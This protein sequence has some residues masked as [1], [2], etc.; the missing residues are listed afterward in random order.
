MT[1][2]GALTVL[3]A[4]DD[5]DGL[6]PNG[7]LVHGSD[8]NFY[9]TTLYGGSHNLG[10]V[11]KITPAG[12]LTTLH[13]FQGSP[14]DGADPYRGLVQGTDGNFYGT[15]MNGGASG[16]CSTG[17]GTVFRIT[18]R[19]GLTTLHSFSVSDGSSPQAGLLQGTDGNFYG[20][21]S[22]GGLYSYGTVFKLSVG[23]KPFVASQTYSG[24]VG[25]NVIILGNNLTGS[26]A[27]S[28]NG[29]ASSFNV[30]SAS[31]IT[32]TVPADATTGKIDVTTPSGTLTSNTPFYVTP[33]VLSFTPPSGAVGTQVQI[34]G[35]SLTQ[36]AGVTFGGVKA[37][38]FTVDSDT[39][40]TAT[41]PT[42]A[43]TGVVGISTPGGTAWSA[44]NFTVQ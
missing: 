27:V 6:N 20:T 15:T 17:C 34:T 4:F 42:S 41:V 24:I 5:T 28:F 10:T 22:G 7:E 9:G 11:F 2:A 23:L 21:T 18:P 43:V 31:E 29:T 8:G 33:Q 30:V 35:V 26:T 25:A 1:S 12:K 39:Q 44:T 37:T 32:T 13:S 38:S 19:G 14:V 40:I 3:H 16:N 36:T